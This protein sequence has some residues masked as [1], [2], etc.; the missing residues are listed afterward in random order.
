MSTATNFSF[1]FGYA[2]RKEF[3]HKGIVTEAGKALIEL[4]KQ[5]NIPYIIATYDKNNPRRL[6]NQ[7]PLK[8]TDI[9]FCV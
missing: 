8:N 3:W 6:Q 9:Q 1:D 7:M 4:Q 2:L 5:D